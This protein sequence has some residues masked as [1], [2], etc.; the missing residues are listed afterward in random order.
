MAE[1]GGRV[2]IGTP[3]CRHGNLASPLA[4]SGYKHGL[5]SLHPARAPPDCA[6]FALHKADRRASLARISKEGFE[7]SSDNLAEQGLFG[8]VALVLDGA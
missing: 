5:R 4:S 6:Y 7:V 2:S 1:I 8:L 3:I